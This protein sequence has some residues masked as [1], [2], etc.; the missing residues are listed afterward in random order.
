MNLI[1]KK[2]VPC[3]VNTS[4]LPQDK[5]DLLL[6]HIEGWTMEN[7]HLK[8]T[9]KFKNFLDAMIFVNQVAIVA[10]E[11]NHHPDIIITWNKVTCDLFTHAI[12]GLSENDFI[13]AAKINKII[14]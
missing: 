4:P 8:K 5:I 6:A 10:E 11:E 12:K 9:F 7:G 2:C 14:S 3:T 1:E 13:M